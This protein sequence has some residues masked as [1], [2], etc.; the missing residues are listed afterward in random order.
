MA[1]HWREVRAEVAEKL[2]EQ[3]VS[4]ASKTMQEEVLI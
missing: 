2:D 3:A 1:R 4:N